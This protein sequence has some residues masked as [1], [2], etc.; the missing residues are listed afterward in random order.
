MGFFV[1]QEIFNRYSHFGARIGTPRLKCVLFVPASVNVDRDF[2]WHVNPFFFFCYKD[3]A[4]QG[5]TAEYS[6]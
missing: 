4:P 3:L 6:A 2:L 5:L 1:P